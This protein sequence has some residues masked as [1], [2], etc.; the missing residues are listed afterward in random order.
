MENH[1]YEEARLAVPALPQ[2]PPVPSRVPETRYSIPPGE[3]VIST[4]GYAAYRPST[5][6]EQVIEDT[7]LGIQSGNVSQHFILPDVDTRSTR[8]RCA[9]VPASGYTGLK[10]NIA[11]RPTVIGQDGYAEYIDDGH[12][13][14]PKPYA[15]LKSNRPRNDKAQTIGGYTKN[16]RSGKLSNYTDLTTGQKESDGYAKYNASVHN[17]HNSYT[18]LRTGQ[19]R[20]LPATPPDENSPCG[21]IGVSQRHKS[22]GSVCSLGTIDEVLDDSDIVSS[23]NDGRVVKTRGRIQSSTSDDSAYTNPDGDV[24]SISYEVVGPDIITLSNK[25]ESTEHIAP[26]VYLDLDEF[27]EGDECRLESDLCLNSSS[28]K[29]FYF[30]KAQESRP[31]YFKVGDPCLGSSQVADDSNEKGSTCNKYQCQSESLEGMEGDECKLTSDMCVNPDSGDRY[32]FK[33][34]K[35]Q[36][37]SPYYFKVGDPRLE[38]S[39]H[40]DNNNEAQS[41]S[42]IDQSQSE[43]PYYFRVRSLRNK[44]TQVTSFTSDSKKRSLSEPVHSELEKPGTISENTNTCPIN[45]TGNQSDH[46]SA[47]YRRKTSLPLPNEINKDYQHLVRSVTL[48]PIV[49]AQHYQQLNRDIKK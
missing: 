49:E 45:M 18:D 21:L 19:D 38:S 15:Q 43:S 35:S 1:T 22:V 30:Q 42:N 5:S 24:E 17:Q 46:A 4:D 2:T 37:Q 33:F 32:Y 3:V 7:L 29:R 48:P 10:I 25:G 6:T 40:V 26:G 39:Q 9:T 8:P 20:R 11:K 28:D 14:Q 13:V 47:K 41:A 12:N 34:Q 23:K 31:Y 27:Y 44:P 16:N 36:E